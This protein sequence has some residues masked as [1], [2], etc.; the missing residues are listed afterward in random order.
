MSGYGGQEIII[1][2]ERSRIIVV[3]AMHANYDW[4]RIV[5][6]KI[7]SGSQSS[8]STV[9]VKQPDIDPQQLILDN[10]AKQEAERI[11]KQY[12]DNY[13]A[14]ILFG[15]SADWGTSTDG[16]TMFS[17]D[18]ENSDKRD[19]R[20]D[21]SSGKWYIKQDNDGNSIFCNK[22]FGVWTSFQF[23]NEDWSN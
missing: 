1:D 15:A 19:V 12:W 5:Y 17:E 10:K 8:I 6:E 18:F 13:T 14:M 9:K 20:V 2:V 16:S 3:N 4:K 7:K 11:A 23:G 21:V 22:P